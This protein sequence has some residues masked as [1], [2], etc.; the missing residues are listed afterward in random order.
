MIESDVKIFPVPP[1]ELIAKWDVIEPLIGSALPCTMRRYLAIDVLV[2]CITGVAQGWFI[3]EGDKLL[4]VMVT[5]IDVYPRSKGLTIFA[6]A[7]ERLAEFFEQANEV[8][9]DYARR[10]GCSFLECVGRQGW[11]KVLNLEPRATFLVRDLTND[12]GAN[13]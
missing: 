5:K 6:L 1:N 7:G 8:V 11:Q 12:G 9:S 2:M 4:A 10:M 3:L 13:A